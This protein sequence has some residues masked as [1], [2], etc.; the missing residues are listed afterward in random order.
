VSIRHLLCGDDEKMSAG[1]CFYFV[2]PGWMR[3]IKE[4]P[5]G[6]SRLRTAGVGLLAPTGS[7]ASEAG[8]ALNCR[9]E[10]VAP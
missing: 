9:V 3:W 7:N 1:A 4:L 5:S 10:L 8:R 2:L 6:R